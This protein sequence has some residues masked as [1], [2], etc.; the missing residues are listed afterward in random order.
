[1]VPLIVVQ[2]PPLE[3]YVD[4]V[5][6]LFEIAQRVNFKLSIYRPLHVVTEP[7]YE[8]SAKEIVSVIDEYPDCE[9][10]D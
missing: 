2:I 9:S 1:M 4:K 6:Q 8:T 10:A 3:P 5:V 7:I